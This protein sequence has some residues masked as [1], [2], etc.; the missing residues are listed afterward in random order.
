MRFLT[1]VKQNLD[2][3]QNNDLKQ[4]ANWIF[5]S[6]L[7][8]NNPHAGILQIKAF[9]SSYDLSHAIHRG[10]S[11]WCVFYCHEPKNMVPNYLKEEMR[12]IMTIME[13]SHNTN[14]IQPREVIYFEFIPIPTIQEGEVF[15][16]VGFDHASEF[17]FNL[18]IANEVSDKNILQKIQELMEDQN[19]KLHNCPFELVMYRAPHLEKQ[20]NK[21]IETEK[22]KAIFDEKRFFEGANQ[23]IT[24]IFKSLDKRSKR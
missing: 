12:A 4:F 14:T 8:K 22:G 6:T 20:I 23:F 2:S 11:K 18:G 16:C 1:F 19:F 5:K 10:F 9:M 3:Q 15:L 17:C 21:L 13:N 24:D 7:G